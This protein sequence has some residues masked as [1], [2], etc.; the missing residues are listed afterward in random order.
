M[1]PGFTGVHERSPNRSAANFELWRFHVLGL[2]EFWILLLDTDGGIEFDW[3]DGG[4][5]AGCGC[6]LIV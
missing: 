1:V 5:C 3:S 2:L 6:R 4:W